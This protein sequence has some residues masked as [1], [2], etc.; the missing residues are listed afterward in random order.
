MSVLE[1]CFV[2]YGTNDIERLGSTNMIT[3]RDKMKT[4]SKKNYFTLPELMAVKKLGRNLCMA[5]ICISG[6]SKKQCSM[7][8]VREVH[9]RLP[10]FV[11]IWEKQNQI[12]WKGDTW[13]AKRIDHESEG[14]G[15]KGSH[16]LVEEFA[17]NAACDNCIYSWKEWC[18][19]VSRLCS[20]DLRQNW[21][22]YLLPFSRGKT[23]ESYA[24]QKVGITTNLR[25]RHTEHC[26]R[27]QRGEYGGEGLWPA[28][29]YAITCDLGKIVPSKS[30]QLEK[31]CKAAIGNGR[32]PVRG[33]EWF[34]VSLIQAMAAVMGVLQSQGLKPKVN[35]EVVQVSVV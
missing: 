30:R 9:R 29:W 33:D 17:M 4:W 21:Y 18:S 3:I 6:Q 5:K 26:S 8:A 24:I 31:E 22:L 12:D 2:S 15:N 34:E 35:D 11:T 10:E 32:P 27:G 23:D 14:K 16:M 20:E 25:N 1:G 13:F 28:W 19:L 7:Y